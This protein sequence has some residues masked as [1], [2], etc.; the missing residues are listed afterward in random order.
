MPAFIT[1]L[2][3][4]ASFTI[5]SKYELKSLMKQPIKINAPALE[6]LKT[7]TDEK[8]NPESE[9]VDTT[10]HSE[11]DKKLLFHQQSMKL[12]PKEVSIVLLSKLQFS[13]SFQAGTQNG[14]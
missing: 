8:L 10:S 6:E 14:S 7:P 4:I 5:A 11:T 2:L 9:K 12:M 13:L 1:F 3:V